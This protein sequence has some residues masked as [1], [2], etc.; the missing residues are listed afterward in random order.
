MYLI[1]I[2]YK[3]NYRK[4]ETVNMVLFLKIQ[5]KD[6]VGLTVQASRNKFGPSLLFYSSHQVY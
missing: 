2:I 1:V 5:L 6:T 4:A 3:S